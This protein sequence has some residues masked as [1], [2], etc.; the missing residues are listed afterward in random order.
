MIDLAVNLL[1][2]GLGLGAVFFVG[3]GIQALALPISGEWRKL[4]QAAMNFGLGTVALT[5]W[6]LALTLA[7]IPFSLQVTLV[8][9]VA[10]SGVIL[11]LKKRSEKG[12]VR[13]AHPAENRKPKTENLVWDRIFLALLALLLLFA[14]LRATFYPMWAWDEIATWGC[15]AQVYFMSL[16]LDLTC[17]EAHNYYPNLVPFLLT[18]LYLCLG[19]VNDHLAKA[20]FP[21][22]GAMLLV[23]LGF[24][25]RRMGLTRT[26]TRGTVAF[27]ALNGTVFIVHLHL[28][29]ADLALA[30]FA[31]GG[32]GLIYLW[33]QDKAP[34]GSLAVA[35]VMFAGMAW[36]KYEGPPLAGTVLLAA[37]LTLLWLRPPGLGGRL[38]RLGIPGAGLASGYLPWKV[39]LIK[40]QIEAGSDHIMGFYPH[41]L[42]PSLGYLV[43]GLFNPFYFGILWPA[44]FLALVWAGR[45]LFNSASLFLA[46]FLGG[47][48]LAVI[49]AYVV[50]PTG[51]AEFEMYVRATL[52]R[53]LLHL[54][55]VAAL[56]VGEGVK[57]LGEGPGANKSPALF[58][59]PHHNPL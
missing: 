54:T 23:I 42:L 16:S 44:A 32:A 8:P 5:L 34:R 28:A 57:E 26:Q 46:L 47:N 55:P 29:Y 56:A 6:M 36:C 49:L 2:L 43:D 59:N 17:I 58:P 51:A 35:A 25:L 52:D 18:Y 9:P 7:G 4:E 21:L 19:Q 50:A 11:I 20:V 38:L 40:N 30:Y 12:M 22:W 41:Q 31:L 14:T 13:R 1:R 33:L 3:H 27:F 37:A 48:L 53:L 15:K 39:Y 10:L 45:R 24:L